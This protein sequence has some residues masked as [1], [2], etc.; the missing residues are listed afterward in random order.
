M[1]RPRMRDCPP[2]TM[3]LDLYG[4]L[5]LRVERSYTAVDVAELVAWSL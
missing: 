3:L 1:V 4:E 2:R 5:Q